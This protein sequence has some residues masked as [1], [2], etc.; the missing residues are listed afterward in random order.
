[1]KRWMLFLFLAGMAAVRGA[2]LPS[3]AV[4]DFTSDIHTALTHGLPDMVSD[5]LVNSGRFDVYEREKLNSV[6]RE[7]GLQ[8]SGM[9]DPATAV[10]L[11]KVAGV[12]YILT[13]EILDC[14]HETRNFSGYGVN[15]RTTFYRL[16]AGIKVIDV[17]T[18]RVL[19]S[20]KDGAEE[21][22]SDSGGLSS[23]DTTMDSKLAEEVS[24]KL[25]KALMEDDS[26]K[27]PGES[28]ATLIPV[29]VTSTPE[30]ADIEVDGVF[31]GNAGDEL[32]LPSG[33]HLVTISQSGYEQWSKKVLVREGLTI[34]ATLA[35]KA[36]ARIEIQKRP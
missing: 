25:T 27:A 6:M 32:K 15:T 16:K 1:M 4:V 18:G 35:Q 19:F 31:Y 5:A 30:H 33:L 21:K 14:G 23:Y 26:F 24:G 2:D 22:V 34:H 29:K 3:I 28:A 10:A 11:G 8:S 36:D 9:V 12:H 20:K 7:Q 13:G 17:K